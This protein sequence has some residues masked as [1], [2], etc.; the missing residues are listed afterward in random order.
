MKT[1]HKHFQKAIDLNPDDESWV[2]KVK[3]EMKVTTAGKG[4][5]K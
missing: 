5:K 1:A 2:T 3:E 4:K